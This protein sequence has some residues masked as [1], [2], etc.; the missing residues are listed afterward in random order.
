MLRTRDLGDLGW[1]ERAIMPGRTAWV[2]RNVLRT[3]WTLQ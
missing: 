2:R 3:F 1:D